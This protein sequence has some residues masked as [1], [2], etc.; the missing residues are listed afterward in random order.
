M[1][2]MANSSH[3]V[4]CFHSAVCLLVCHQ[5]LSHSKCQPG[6]SQHFSINQYTELTILGMVNDDSDTDY[7]FLDGDDTDDVVRDNLYGCPTDDFNGGFFEL[8]QA[9][10]RDMV[11]EIN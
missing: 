7:A 10:R 2:R 11:S 3:S 8:E 6:I 9:A 4:Q 1:M 5:S